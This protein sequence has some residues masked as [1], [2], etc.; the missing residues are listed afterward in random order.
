MSI[1]A[2]SSSSSYN[3]QTA[4][5]SYA[6]KLISG[7]G[8]EPVYKSYVNDTLASNS[9]T[10]W[11]FKI[12]D[13]GFFGAD[14]NKAA[15]LP[16]DIK[17][18]QTMMAQAENY[19]KTVGNNV[20]PMSVIS[21]AWNLYKT[22]AGSSLDPDNDGYMTQ[23]ELDAMP[24]SYVSKGGI[25]D[26]VTSVQKTQSDYNDAWVFENNLQIATQAKF[27]SG[28]RDISII[29]IENSRGVYAASSG[30]DYSDSMPEDKIAVGQ[31]FG[32]FFYTNME[33]EMSPYPSQSSTKAYGK[34][35]ESGQDIKDYLENTKGKDYLA[36][37]TKQVGT[38]VDGTFDPSM[39][40]KFFDELD[41]E[42]KEQMAQ[43]KANNYPNLEPS[44]S[45]K[46]ELSQKTQIP[47]QNI[48]SSSKQQTSANKTAQVGLSSVLQQTTKA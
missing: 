17:I 27:S 48:L 13:K 18:H 40:D 14:F 21:K 16:E 6:D 32:D 34:F 47:T 46:D 8:I 23:K 29:S 33:S 12:D 41:K 15:G 44:S 5:T 37:L 45:K 30:V 43:V 10:K 7:N 28:F 3:Y 26:G 39:I 22:V 42:M 4:N 31:L 19:S 24:K 1:S 9:S 25:L 20:D 11:G 35:L 36:K 38:K 2:V